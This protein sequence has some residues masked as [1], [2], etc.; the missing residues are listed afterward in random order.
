MEC[1]CHGHGQDDTS[2]DD[3]GD[4]RQCQ[5]GA[6]QAPGPPSPED[7]LI[8]WSHLASPIEEKLD[9][10]SLLCAASP[11][12]SFVMKKSFYSDKS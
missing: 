1:L 5:L 8:D 9:D 3:H 11:Y 6:D 2:S 10:E 4:S 7:Q 12:V